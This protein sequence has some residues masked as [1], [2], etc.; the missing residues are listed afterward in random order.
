MK[1][2][3]RRTKSI[4]KKKLK[5]LEDQ[6]DRVEPEVR[7]KTWP[8]YFVVTER[9]TGVIS[10]EF[11]FLYAINKKHAAWRGN[12]KATKTLLRMHP[13]SMNWSKEY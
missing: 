10:C 11:M 6:Y 3:K 8:K 2:F 12:R 7:R 1:F 4:G 9:H 13:A 5:K